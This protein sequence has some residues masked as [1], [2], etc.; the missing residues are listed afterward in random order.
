MEFTF[1]SLAVERVLCFLNDVFVV[2]GVSSRCH[3]NCLL[4]VAQQVGTAASWL[5][6]QSFGGKSGPTNCVANDFGCCAT[7]KHHT[8]R[9]THTVKQ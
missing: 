5:V 7:S 6:W 2:G 8:A 4:C 1:V 3:C 9:R